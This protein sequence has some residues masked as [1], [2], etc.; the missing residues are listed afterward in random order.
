MKRINLITPKTY[1][2]LDLSIQKKF[3]YILFSLFLIYFGLRG[4]YD[5][6]ELQSSKRDLLK[7]NH[8]IGQLK[9]ALSEKRSI[10]EKTTNIEKEFSSIAADYQILKK[11]VVIK[12]IFA[13]ISKI[14]PANTWITSLEFQYYGEK[15]LLV[16]GKSL[17]KEEIFTF[18]KNSYSIGKNSELINMQADG[19]NTFNFEIK[20]ELL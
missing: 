9:L 10:D 7:I 16:K 14:I 4:L 6:N 5:Y 12:D 18:L 2:P 3:V 8:E 19:V 17:H 11:E 15:S 1:F 20:M 13:M